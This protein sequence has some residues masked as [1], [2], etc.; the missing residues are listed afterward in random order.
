MYLY[1]SAT[2]EEAPGEYPGVNGNG[3]AAPQYDADEV[4]FQCIPW[5]LEDGAGQKVPYK[6]WG[7]ESS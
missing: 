4:Q 5:G 6:G 3:V 1:A 2:C 7:V